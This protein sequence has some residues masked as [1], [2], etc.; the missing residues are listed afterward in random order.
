MAICFKGHMLCFATDARRST[1]DLAWALFS[2]IQQ[3][4]PER[5]A[6]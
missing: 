2:A 1:Q 4:Y 6:K 3:S 5:L